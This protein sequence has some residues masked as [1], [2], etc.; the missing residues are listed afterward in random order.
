MR[1]LTNPL[2]AL[3][4]L[5]VMT[6]VGAACSSDAFTTANESYGATADYAIEEPQAAP[7]EADYDYAT[8]VQEAADDAYDGDV[9]GEARQASL[10]GTG[11][12]GSAQAQLPDLGRDI[13]Y[14]ATLDLGSTDVTSTVRDAISTVEARGGFL[15]TQQLSG[16]ANASSTLV[17]KVLPEQFQNVLSELGTIGSV[18]AQ[19]VNAKDVTAVVVDLESRISTAELS[20]ERLR[21]FLENADDITTIAE[22]ERE[23]LERETVLEQ[24]RGQLRTVQ[25]QVDLATITVNITELLNLPAMSVRVASYAGHDGGFDCFENFSA[26]VGQVGD[27]MTLCYTVTNEGDTPLVDIEFADQT[28]GIDFDS[29]LVVDGSPSRLD[30]GQTVVVAHEFELAESQRLVNSFVAIGLD[31]D[32]NRLSEPVQARGA[33]LRFEVTSPTDGVPGFGEVLSSSWNLLKTIVLV[34]AL[35]LVAIAPFLLVALVA[36]PVL[37]WAWRRLR[38][39][40]LPSPPTPAP[41]PSGSDT[42]RDASGDDAETA[43]TAKMS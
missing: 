27:A 40:R 2:K 3:M 42:D 26:R 14:T 39:K 37:L 22:L 8:D 7:A 6:L 16:G 33:T 11:T 24:Y 12:T 9:D 17:F 13:V 30:P 18:R 32:G 41:S 25:N 31:A 34:I 15:F 5:L 38:V 23:L 10:T 29:L 20:V 36:V 4:I 19:S 21:G 35:A 1:T 43:E 28:L